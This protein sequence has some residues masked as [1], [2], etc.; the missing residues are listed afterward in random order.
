RASLD[1]LD[2][3]GVEGW[4]DHQLNMGSAYD[5]TSDNWPTHLERTIEISQQAEPNVGWYETDDDGT[6]YFNEAN[7]DTRWL[8]GGTMYLGAQNIQLWDRINSVSE[9]RMH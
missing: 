4:I 7:G 5:S 3:L 6:A 1:Q 9:W 8:L 2:I